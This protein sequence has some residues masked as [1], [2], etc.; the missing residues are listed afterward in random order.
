MIKKKYL[1]REKDLDAEGSGRSSGLTS[2]RDGVVLLKHDDLGVDPNALG[3][4]V[5]FVDA[6]ETIGDLKHV[7]PQR[8]DDELSILRLFLQRQTHPREVERPVFRSSPPVPKPHHTHV[9]VTSHNGDVFE[10]QRS[11]D[12]VHEVER[13][14]LVVV[15]SEHQSQGAEGLLSSRQVEDLFPALLRGTDTE[16]GTEVLSSDQGGTNPSLRYGVASNLNMMPSEKGSKLS[17]SSSSASP[18][19]VSI[20]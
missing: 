16:K 4:V 14:G 3:G 19:R 6:D 1:Q 13:R 12:L 20:W 5:S 7:V 17:T 18:P 2:G 8:D 11:V 15:Q 10:V 9:D